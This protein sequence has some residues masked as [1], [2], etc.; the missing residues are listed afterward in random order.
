MT[1]T[2]W[3]DRFHTLTRGTYTRTGHDVT[4]HG[5]R[6][7]HGH[8]GAVWYLMGRQLPSH[9]EPSSTEDRLRH[10]NMPPTVA[11]RHS[12]RSSHTAKPVMPPM[13]CKPARCMTVP[14]AE[15]DLVC[16]MIAVDRLLLLSCNGRYLF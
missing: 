7:C 4:H 8:A 12:D 10:S 15:A 1:R 16:G 2:G 13:S 5:R 11:A 3:S 9:D 14:R 6:P